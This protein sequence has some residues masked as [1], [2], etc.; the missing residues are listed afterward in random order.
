MREILEKINQLIKINKL[1]LLL[2]KYSLSLL[3]IYLKF[4]IKMLYCVSENLVLY[5]IY[6]FLVLYCFFGCKTIEC[7]KSHYLAFI[8]VTYFMGLSLELF[9]LCKIK[10]T[11]TALFNL[12]GDDYVIQYSDYLM[13]SKQL[14][15]YY[16]VLF[17]LT[18]I[19]EIT[20]ELSH[21]NKLKKIEMLEEI[22]KKVYGVEVEK[23]G[24]EIK[25][26]YVNDEQEILTSNTR[27]LMSDLASKAHVET[28]YNNITNPISDF[29][30][31]LRR[32]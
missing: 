2:K 8:V 25:A 19:E 14:F 11:R 26:E 23:W 22:Y 9:V 13:S 18:G 17:M 6:I 24:E 28:L 4:Q 1:F 7:T 31:Q 16:G 12:I 21:N 27:G 20:L 15:K 32:K 30:E 5:S 3:T 29:L 10:I